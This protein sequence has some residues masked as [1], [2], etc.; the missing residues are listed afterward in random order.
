ML[1]YESDVA[2]QGGLVGLPQVGPPGTLSAGTSVLKLRCFRSVL[3][4]LGCKDPAASLLAEDHILHHGDH[5][6]S[7][8]RIRGAGGVHAP[9]EAEVWSFSLQ[10]VD[11][12]TVALVD[13]RRSGW[14]M[15]AILT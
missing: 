15:I 4:R 10:G 9:G 2:A 3:Q 13:G 6:F 8:A 11:L 1:L 5:G 14:T 7:M 12:R